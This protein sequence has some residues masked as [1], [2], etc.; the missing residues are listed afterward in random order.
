MLRLTLDFALLITWYPDQNFTHTIFGS[1]SGFIY[2]NILN[3]CY[4]TINFWEWNEGFYGRGY[5]KP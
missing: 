1:V 4:G 3:P 5:C 2:C